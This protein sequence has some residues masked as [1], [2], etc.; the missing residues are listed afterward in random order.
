MAR[1]MA[2]TVNIPL[3]PVAAEVETEKWNLRG[4]T[5]CS[6]EGKYPLMW[7]GKSGHR[8]EVRENGRPFGGGRQRG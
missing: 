1:A 3:L 8:G 5:E 2:E 6:V 4:A 7:P